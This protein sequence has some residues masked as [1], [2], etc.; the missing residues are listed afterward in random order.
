[1]FKAGDVIGVKNASGTEIARGISN[2]S[3][4]DAA[5][6]AGARTAEIERILGHKAYDELIH[7]NNMVVLG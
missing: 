1:N 6:I 3:H 5:R 2:Y 4:E 7:R